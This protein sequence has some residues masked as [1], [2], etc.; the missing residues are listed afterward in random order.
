MSVKVAIDGD[1][2]RVSAPTQTPSFYF[3]FDES[4]LATSNLS[5]SWA[6]GSA[7]AV[8]SPGEFTLIML[9]QKKGRREARV[10]STNIAGTK[11][12][13]MDHDRI[14]FDYQMVRPGVY[15]ITPKQAL[16][17]G[18]YGFIYSLSGKGTKGALS[19]R[20]FDFA[21]P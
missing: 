19:A 10:G 17:P 1:A 20:I 15:K 2:A 14:P 5:S 11:T 9:M 3:F 8:T 4:N 18:Q 16:E 21:V 7:Q 6:A 12:G 13:V